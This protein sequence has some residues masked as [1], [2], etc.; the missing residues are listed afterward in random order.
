MEPSVTVVS[1]STDAGIVQ[2]AV[3]AAVKSYKDISGRDVKV[4]CV[5]SDETGSP[6]SICRLPWRM[7]SRKIV[8]AV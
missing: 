2:K 1:R 7:D 3:D 4:G 6:T 5:L 8:Q